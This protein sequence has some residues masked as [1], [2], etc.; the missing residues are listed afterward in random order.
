MTNRTIRAFRIV[1]AAALLAACSHTNSPSK[2]PKTETADGAIASADSA[3]APSPSSNAAASALRDSTSDRADRGRILGDS[4]ATVW[5]V[6]VS[7][8]Q[9]PFCK[10]WHDAAFQQIMKTYVNTGRVRLAFL[11]MPL[12]IHRNAVPASEAAM[13]AS[14]QG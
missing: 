5:V 6:M 4:N 14:V 8:F 9:C 1:V 12:S 3:T 10:Q 13:C 11:N 2:T 7:D